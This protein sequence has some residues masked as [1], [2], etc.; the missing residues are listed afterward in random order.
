MEL[1][2]FA[3]EGHVHLNQYE[4]VDKLP[5][6]APFNVRQEPLLEMKT[7]VTIVFAQVRFYYI[8]VEILNFNFLS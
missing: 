7:I 2:G 5:H 8:I 1:D 4:T 3:L 6:L